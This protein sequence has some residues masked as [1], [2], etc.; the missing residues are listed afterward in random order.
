[1][2]ISWSLFNPSLQ[3]A[4]KRRLAGLPAPQLSAGNS[5]RAQQRWRYF[6]WVHD[7]LTHGEGFQ[8]HVPHDVANF[9]Q[10]PRARPFGKTA[11]NA[12]CVGE[13]PEAICGFTQTATVPHC[14]LMSWMDCLV[15]RAWLLF[16]R[17][18]RISIQSA[19]KLRDA[20]ARNVSLRFG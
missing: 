7:I 17:S 15:S 11:S 10:S 9:T 3:D 12:Y 13:K 19:E 20:S 1:M 18:H 2:T 5:R 6:R 8:F 16:E 14:E 4:L